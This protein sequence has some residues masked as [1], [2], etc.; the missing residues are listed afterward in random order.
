MARKA[1]GG[2]IRTHNKGTPHGG[3]ALSSNA[4]PVRQKHTKRGYTR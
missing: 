2:K 1:R 3:H 4:R